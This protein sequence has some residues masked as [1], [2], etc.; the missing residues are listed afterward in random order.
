MEETWMEIPG[1]EGLYEASSLG[2]IRSVLAHPKGRTPA[3]HVLAAS[4]HRNGYLNVGL[5]TSTGRKVVGVHRLVAAA[6][7]GAPDAGMEACHADGNKLNNHAVN[8]RWGT[9]SENVTDS[10]SA[11]THYS[12]GRTLTHCKHGH[13]F[14][15]ENT[16]RA[17]YGGYPRR[18]CKTCRNA[19]A[20]RYQ[21]RKR[22]ADNRD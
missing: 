5:R 21:Q 1:Y 10:V 11:G 12:H 8:L 14:T 15:T 13:E 7:H 17:V 2:R 18:V 3:N 22:E 20:R 19:T 16:S 4:T 6:F 9:H